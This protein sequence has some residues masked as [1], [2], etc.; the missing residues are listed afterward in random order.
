[1]INND[2]ELT[3][4][5]SRLRNSN[6]LLEK[7]NNSVRGP[8]YSIMALARITLEENLTPDQTSDNLAMI[9]R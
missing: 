8:L 9:E 3:L 1:M 4:L 5:V 2:E 7:L 6:M